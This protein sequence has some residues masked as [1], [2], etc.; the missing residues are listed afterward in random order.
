[1][2]PR[3]HH[4]LGENCYPR[5]PLSVSSI[6]GPRSAPAHEPADEPAAL[7]TARVLATGRGFAVHEYVCHAGPGDRPFEERHDR[8]TIAAVV[9]GAFAY[10]TETGRG[11][12]HPG[13]LLLGNVGACFECGH[14]H[15]RGDRCVSFQFDPELFGELAATAAGSARFRFTAAMMPSIDPLLP[16]LAAAEHAAAESGAPA[17]AVGTSLQ[18]EELALRLT[19]VVL[20]ALTGRA[21][22][23]P[24]GVASRDERRIAEVLRVIEEQAAEALDLDQ[25]AA[26]AGLSKYH[27]LRIFRRVVGRSPYQYL[28]AVRM[29]RA[30]LA[31]L[32]S[33]APVSDIA[34]DAGFGDLSTFNRRF[35]ESFGE[36][37]RGY[38]QRHAS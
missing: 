19:E 18:L 11:F 32:G 12:L 28:L 7:P 5:F 13:A 1:M 15:S 24:P 14:E 8:F 30:A 10:R 38:R 37:P 17:R 4:P 3:R 6:S 34:F 25:L 9:S 26:L 23:P 27:F 16:L 20:A 33:A 36:T 35:R 29:R 21:A 2:P 31:L 22:A